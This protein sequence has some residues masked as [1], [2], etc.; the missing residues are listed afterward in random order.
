[1]STFDEVLLRIQSQLDKMK[2]TIQRGRG[3]EREPAQGG[4]QEKRRETVTGSL[5]KVRTEAEQ[6]R[7]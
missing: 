1:M 5:K 6:I 7:M 3:V 2:S 4:S